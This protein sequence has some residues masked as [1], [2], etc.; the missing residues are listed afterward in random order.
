MFRNL[1]I[2]QGQRDELI[3]AGVNLD[4]SSVGRAGRESKGS[5]VGTSSV[6]VA[7]TLDGSTAKSG[8]ALTLPV[9]TIS[10]T[11]EVSPTSLPELV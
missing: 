1:I 7:G 5:G 4:G 9:S 2:S 8:S 10:S 11:G 3:K 6:Q